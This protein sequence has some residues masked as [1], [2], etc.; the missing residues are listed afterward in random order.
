M[1]SHF[2]LYFFIFTLLQYLRLMT[3]QRLR[4]VQTYFETQSSV[5]ETYRALDPVY[6]RY[7]RPSE[8]AIRAWI[9][10]PLL[11]LHSS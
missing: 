6:G 5:R 2:N 11:Y 9:V 7:S 8:S 4:T 1:F 10:F 3:K